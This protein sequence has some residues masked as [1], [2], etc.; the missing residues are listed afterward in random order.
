MF[1]GVMHV[2]HTTYI[3]NG[4]HWSVPTPMT[5]CNTFL[6]AISPHQR[7]MNTLEE[8]ERS[9]CVMCVLQGSGWKTRRYPRP[10]KD[11]HFGAQGA[12]KREYQSPLATVML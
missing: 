8:T 7:H 4:S 11:A 9:Q 1:E 12:F 5:Q 10:G 2:G 6:H 3:D